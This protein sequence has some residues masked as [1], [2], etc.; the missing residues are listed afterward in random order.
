MMVY[1]TFVVPHLMYGAETW[2]STL[3]QEEK[4]ERLH[5]SCLRCIAGVT[6][7]DRHSNSYVRKLC[8]TQ[9]L[10]SKIIASRLRWLGHVARM[11]NDRYP[12]AAMIGELPGNAS[13]VRPHRSC[14]IS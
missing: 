11:S 2:N 9:T 3:Q 1:N 5:S 4:L 6:S 10:Q 7:Y 14:E 12:K 13:R 8:N